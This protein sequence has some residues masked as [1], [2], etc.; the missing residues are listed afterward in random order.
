MV[1]EILTEE[2]REFEAL[3][4][5]MTEK[6]E[7]KH[8][9]EHGMSDYGSEEEDYDDLFLDALAEADAQSDMVVGRN[10]QPSMPLE[11]D[12]DLSLG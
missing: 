10:D 8:E 1:D 4:C 9:Q 7:S 2:E 11:S 12:M 5:L 3:I 6:V